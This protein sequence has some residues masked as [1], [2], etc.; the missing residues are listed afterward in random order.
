[1]GQK[2]KLSRIGQATLTQKQTLKK[3]YANATDGTITNPSTAPFK[4]NSPVEH[5]TFGTGIV[6]EVETKILGKTIVTVLFKIG[7]K[8]IDAQFLKLI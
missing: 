5:A 1:S 3:I 2:N 8:K 4:K 6:Q 7:T